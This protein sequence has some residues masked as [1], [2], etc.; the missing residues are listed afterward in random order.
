MRDPQFDQL[1]RLLARGLSRRDVLRWLRNGI[2]GGAAASVSGSLVV[3]ANNAPLNSDPWKKLDEMIGAY[4]GFKNLRSEFKKL[5]KEIDFYVSN[6]LACL[7]RGFDAETCQRAVLLCF[8][9]EQMVNIHPFAG[10][11][12]LL[13]I[14]GAFKRDCGKGECFQ[15]CWNGSAC[16][17][18]FIGFPV[19]NCNKNYG[20]ET[21]RAGI[22]LITDPNAK[23]GDACFAILQTCDHV[24]LCVGG[25]RRYIPPGELG[26][27]GNASVGNLKNEVAELQVASP[28]AQ[29]ELLASQ[30][31]IDNRARTFATQLQ[32]EMRAYLEAFTTELPPAD[33]SENASIH[34][35]ALFL[36]GY[37]R[38]GWTSAIM[39]TEAWRDEPFVVKDTNGL[40]VE[41]A[42]RAN[43]AQLLGLTRLLGSV[44]N[45]ASRLAS[46]E[47]RVWS[48]P[49]I[50]AYIASVGDV[51][52]ELLKRMSPVAL[53]MLQRVMALQYY[54]LLAVPLPGEGN[55]GRVFN[56]V[57]LGEPP[58]VTIAYRP[59]GR[60]G[61]ELT[62]TLVDPESD[63]ITLWPVSVD[64]G[65]GQVTRHELPAGQPEYTLNYTYDVGGSY[66]V[67][68]MAEN[69]TGLRGVAAQVVATA[70]QDVTTAPPRT[71]SIAR[72]V[73][74][75]DTSFFGSP[76]LQ[77]DALI[78][79]EDGDSIRAGLSGPIS[80]SETSRSV[81]AAHNPLR[82]NVRTLQLIPRFVGRTMGT[83]VIRLRP[84]AF[85]VFNT[86]TAAYERHT[87]AI[88]PA[89]IQAYYRASAGPVALDSIIREAD[90]TL[91]IPLRAIPP[92]ESFSRIDR[93]D[94]TIAPEL[95]AGFQLS[96]LDLT[97]KIG[98]RASWAE[99]TPGNF[100][101]SSPDPNRVY[102]PMLRRP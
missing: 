70:T 33:L 2:F 72:V 23:P 48:D 101:V 44:P 95:F 60:L 90:G 36:V 59:V 10:A 8:L 22:T 19:I 50:D 1:T 85:D 24:A 81:F 97:S 16:H 25:R 102:L 91:V 76:A 4:K 62:I 21:A 68:A 52:K 87:V 54:G 41:P 18:S 17:S 11:L 86:V 77:V 99:Q 61:V 56:G 96:L 89:L 29:N 94:I 3:Y 28:L 37:G 51:D 84:L 65:N 58:Q 31:A 83:Q 12:G 93:I 57:L 45:V 82:L 49:E 74:D 92:G 14:F 47:S 64:W 73:I 34:E 38:S 80:A 67:L 43:T 66:L 42:S 100:I 6:G 78:V 5:Y 20:P 13:D 30:A 26:T 35:L 15:C 75:L 63:K 40:P 88:P 98:E 27:P 79:D 39:S 69:K 32:T 46:V 71:P 53:E 55:P 7:D 9:S